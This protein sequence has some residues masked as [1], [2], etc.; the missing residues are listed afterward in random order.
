MA[1]AAPGSIVRA[2]GDGYVDGDDEATL[3]RPMTRAPAISPSLLL[4]PEIWDVAIHFQ[5]LDSLELK[6]C[7]DDVVL[8]S[9]VALKETQGYVSTDSVYFDKGIGVDGLEKIDSN[10]KL[11]QLK[12]QHKDAKLLNLSV[13][14]GSAP[15]FED[16]LVTQE[17]QIV[18]GRQESRNEE[19]EQKGKLKLKQVVE[20]DSTDASSFDSEGPIDI[21]HDP[22]FMG[23]YRPKAN[24]GRGLTLEEFEQEETND[25][26]TDSSGLDDEVL[27]ERS[28]EEELVLLLEEVLVLVL[29]L[30]EV[31]EE[32]ISQP[33]DGLL[34]LL[35]LAILDGLVT[36]M[37]VVIDELGDSKAG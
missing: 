19:R 10:K 37:L 23:K 30:V 7:S 4:Y 25:D 29:V 1:A 36:S 24:E 12:R 28:L 9:V 17:S 5:D 32:E 35:L 16:V 21:E 31:L 2:G 26:E 11:Q 14:R 8:P 18:V 27:P 34:V 15:V 33:Q 13:Y 3:I 6:L 22:Y 20:E